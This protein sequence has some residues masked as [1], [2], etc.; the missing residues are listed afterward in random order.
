MFFTQSLKKYEKGM[1]GALITFFDLFQ[2]NVS[3]L[4][5]LK[6]SENEK[7][8]GDIETEHWLEMSSN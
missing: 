2:T 4:Y 7:F 1:E 3:F 5:S 6:T 8:S